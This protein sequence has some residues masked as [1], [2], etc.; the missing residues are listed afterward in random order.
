MSLYAI[1]F[2]D[3]LDAD[4]QRRRMEPREA[5]RSQLQCGKCRIG[6][7]F[8]AIT[9]Q[10]GSQKEWMVTV[11]PISRWDARPSVS[12]YIQDA[13]FM[14]FRDGEVNF[15]LEKMADFKSSTMPAKRFMRWAQ[16]L[17]KGGCGVARNRETETAER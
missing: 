7:D 16:H 5:A 6:F 17:R 10:M 9:V 8:D 4:W 3:P 1:N 11:T 2:V 15:L 12:W 14:R 13:D